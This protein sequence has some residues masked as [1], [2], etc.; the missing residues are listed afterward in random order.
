MPFKERFFSI[1]LTTKPDCPNVISVVNHVVDAIVNSVKTIHGSIPDFLYD[2]IN[3]ITGYLPGSLSPYDFQN[4][5]P[6]THMQYYVIGIC[7]ALSSTSDFFKMPIDMAFGGT[8]PQLLHDSLRDDRNFITFIWY[9][10]PVKQHPTSNEN[11]SSSTCLPCHDGKN[12]SAVVDN[13]LLFNEPFD[14]F[15]P[16]A[17]VVGDVLY[18]GS[19]KIGTSELNSFH[20]LPGLNGKYVGTEFVNHLQF[21]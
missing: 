7:C 17:Y 3:A 18:H 4:H 14:E 16:L 20:L 21:M 5:Y 13:H 2:D 9:K 11:V 19:N 15:V 8:N 12:T 1:C 6:P 10:L